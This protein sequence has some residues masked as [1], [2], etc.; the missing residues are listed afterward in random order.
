MHEVDMTKCL[1]LS[2]NQWKHQHGPATPVVERVHLQVGAFTCVEPDQLVTT[3]QVAVR[4]S[5]LDG[6]ELVIEAVPLVGRCL[7]CNATYSPD[8]RQAYRSPCCDQPMEEIVS[9]RELRIRSVEYLP[10]DQPAVPQAAD[11]AIDPASSSAL[12]SHAAAS[13]L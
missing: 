10:G 3:W 4:G 5:W 1:L 8:P 2:M 13:A 6:A 7:I 9:G 11:P 12:H